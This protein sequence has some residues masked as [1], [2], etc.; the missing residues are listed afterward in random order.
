MKNSSISALRK[1]VISPLTFR[2]NMWKYFLE[3]GCYTYVLD[4]R[5]DKFFLIGDFIGE[6][7]TEHVSDQTLINTLVKEMKYFGI[8]I[9]TSETD[10]IPK[11]NQRKIYLQREEHSGYYHLLRQDSN[12]IW[13]HKFPNELPIQTDSIGETILDPDCMIEAPFSGWCFVLQKE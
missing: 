11:E 3:A 13:S 12:G 5:M 10:Y 8:T 6:R 2:P 1:S 4:L 7:C 9:K